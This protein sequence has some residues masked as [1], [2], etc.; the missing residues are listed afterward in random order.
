MKRLLS[1]LLLTLVSGVAPLAQ[2]SSPSASSQ[3]PSPAATSAPAASQDDETLRACQICAARLRAAD[4]KVAALESIITDK[5]KQLAAKDELLEIRAQVIAEF[6]GI[7]TRSQ[8][9]DANA[10]RDAQLADMG[11]NL[12]REQVRA[13]AVR[14]TD[15][16]DDLS[17]CQSNQ[18]WIAGGSAL[19]GGVM[20]YFLHKNQQQVFNLIPGL[21][22]VGGGGGGGL[23]FTNYLPGP[24]L[25]ETSPA[26]FRLDAATERRL[27]EAL[28][29]ARGELQQ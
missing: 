5:D 29:R 25:R 10:Q 23:T 16:T 6:K 12:L 28:G 13:D 1:T 26:G 14:I 2:T 20:T 17:G 11:I 4:A 22:G 21:A 18:K 15:L 7:D 24:T 19:A 8:R 9:M 27:R 3:P